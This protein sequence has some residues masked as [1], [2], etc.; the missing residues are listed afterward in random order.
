MKLSSMLKSAA[1]RS[2]PFPQVWDTKREKRVDHRRQ[3]AQ[4]CG[5]LQMRALAVCLVVVLFLTI[6][7]CSSFVTNALYKHTEHHDCI[8]RCKKH[9]GFA[10]SRCVEECDEK[11]GRAPEGVSQ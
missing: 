7:G 2:I 3:S 10:Q 9:Y 11:Y 8:E 1:L 4:R 6:G 5:E